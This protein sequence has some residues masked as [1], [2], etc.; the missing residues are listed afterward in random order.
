MNQQAKK[1]TGPGRPV[2]AKTADRDVVDVEVSRCKRCGST[3]RAKYSSKIEVV[4]NGM[5]DGK[6]Y[7]SVTVRHTQCLN[8][9]CG[10]HRV[11][12]FYQNSFAEI[13]QV[14]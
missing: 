1:Q 9:D 3:D 2:G 10:Q 5:H 11:D 12:R 13:P 8:P 4:G 14:N 6:P 7:T